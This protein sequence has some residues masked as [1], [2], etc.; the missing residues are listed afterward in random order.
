MARR[1]LC[2]E[3]LTAR[4]PTRFIP[5]AHDE[6]IFKVRMWHVLRRCN[7]EQAPILRDV[8]FARRRVPF[9]SSHSRPRGR[10]SLARQRLRGPLACVVLYSFGFRVAPAEA[11]Q[12]TLRRLAS[13]FAAA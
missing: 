11:Y 4:R 3:F 10:P 13:A 12:I 8:G 9:D 2:T 1:S 7:Q 6:I 5:V